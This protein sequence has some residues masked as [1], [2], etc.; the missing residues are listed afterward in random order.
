MKR[1]AAALALVLAL[2]APGRAQLMS[3][4]IGQGDAG[5]AVAVC[6]GYVGPGDVA[7]GASIGASLRAW[8]AATCGNRFANVCVSGTCA[9]MLTSATTGAI[10]AQTINGTAC[11]AASTS[12]CVV[13][14]WYDQTASGACTGSCDFVQTGTEQRG[15]L[16]TTCIS[17]L[18]VCVLFPTS[19]STF[20]QVAGNITLS[21]PFSVMAVDTITFSGSS[22][23]AYVGFNNNG[24]LGHSTAANET[25]YTCDAV[26]IS[27]PT[28]SDGTWYSQI[29]Q[30]AAS[31]YNLYIDG[32]PQSALAWTA[33]STPYQVY[34]GGIF[35]SGPVIYEVEVGI[36]KSDITASA[37][38]LS[39]NQRAYW[40]F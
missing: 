35:A 18:T 2:C 6:G 12:A 9:D 39:A 15:I 24:L 1:L 38:A 3:T 21:A 4:G 11:P 36:W 27:L 19:T 25:A 30:C 22:S 16:T 23:P 40:G 10:V 8:T 14:K 13:N 32:A 7:T 20:L 31:T 26:A 33:T 17:P 5:G 28:T 34:I 29:V 37:S